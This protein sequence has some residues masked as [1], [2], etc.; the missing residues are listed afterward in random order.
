MEL[1]NGQVTKKKI[2]K[3][4]KLRKVFVSSVGSGIH[5]VSGSELERWRQHKDIKDINKGRDNTKK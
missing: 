2:N 1:G 3:K 4:I 5:W